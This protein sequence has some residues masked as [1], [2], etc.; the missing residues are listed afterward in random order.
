MTKHE[1]WELDKW[2][3]EG[4]LSEEEAAVIEKYRKMPI[5]EWPRGMS[6]MLEHGFTKKEVII[7]QSKVEAGPLAW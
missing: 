4:P 1:R 5:E 2:M 6:S 7:L 3:K